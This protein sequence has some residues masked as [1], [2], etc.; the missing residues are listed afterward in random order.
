MAS[1]TSGGSK[2]IATT[3]IKLAN[4]TAVLKGHVIIRDTATDPSSGVRSAAAA[5]PLLAGVALEDGNGSGS[6]VLV[7]YLGEVEVLNTS[8]AAISQGDLLVADNLGGVAAAVA[9]NVNL[10]GDA[11]MDIAD[12]EMGLA[13]VNVRQ[14]ILI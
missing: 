1:A 4:A 2:P 11:A 7:C 9:T 8:G 14:T 10:I 5:A 3:T 13:V 12:G 6:E